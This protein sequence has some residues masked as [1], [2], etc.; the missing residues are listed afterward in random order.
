MALLAA[1]AVLGSILVA[2]SQARRINRP[3]VALADAAQQLGEGDFAVRAEPAGMP[4]VDRAGSALNATAHRLGELVARERDFTSN[5]SHQ[6]RTPLTG[7][8]LHLEAGLAGDDAAAH[9]ALR[10]AINSADE[11][12]R[13]VD[14]LLT[15]SR[16]DVVSA[17]AALDLSHVLHDLEQR[18]HGRLAAVGR[19]LVVRVAPEARFA[20]A[21]DYAVRQA[22]EVLVDNA[23][24]H[25][26]GQVTVATREVAGAIAID[27]QDEGPG[28]AQDSA[29][30]FARSQPD[31]RSER[32]G[33]GI[34]LP[35]AQ[36]LVRSHGGRLVPTRRTGATVF[37]LLL[38][39]PETDE[40]T[41]DEDGPL[42][43]QVDFM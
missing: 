18:W 31:V 2:R 30:L 32:R 39:A 15:H 13:T 23:T 17:Q 4:E 22:L 37:T 10:N 29:S 11:L 8:R 27:V 26:R 6:L 19:R 1:L 5:A 14:D 42:G 28:P 40:T 7:L 41:D 20:L 38:R 9:A 36:D 16:Q 35:M 43:S 12:E 34:G 24:V 33:H 3:L 25:G 21:P